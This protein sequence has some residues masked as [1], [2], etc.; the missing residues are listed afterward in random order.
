VAHPFRDPEKDPAEKALES[1]SDGSQVEQRRIETVEMLQGQL[2][3]GNIGK[4][5]KI[6]II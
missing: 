1:V 6:C 5:R 4:I 2:G 3:I